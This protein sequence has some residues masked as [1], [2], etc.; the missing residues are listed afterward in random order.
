M[1]SEDDIWANSDDDNY[2]NVIAEK[3]W[4]R[5]QENHGNVS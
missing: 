2:D 4:L 1:A 3:D 5:M